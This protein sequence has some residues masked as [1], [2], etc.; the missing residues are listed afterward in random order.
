[1]FPAPRQILDPVTLPAPVSDF[2]GAGGLSAALLDPLFDIAGLIPG[3]NI[4]V[5][6]GVDGTATIPNGGNA[7]ILAGNGGNGF[8][9]TVA[10]TGNG[11]TAA[12]A[13]TPVCS[14]G[15]AATA[16][17]APPASTARPASIP[18]QVAPPLTG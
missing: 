18:T 14:S 2:F 11:G 9:R 6:N 8:S 1:M 10:G 5:G 4:F 15:M 12:T 16:A 13:A 7:G 17:T 3:L